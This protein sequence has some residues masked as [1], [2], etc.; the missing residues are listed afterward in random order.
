MGFVCEGIAQVNINYQSAQARYAQKRQNILAQLTKESNITGEQ[1]T[2]LLQD[3]FAAQMET[4]LLSPETDREVGYQTIIGH[5][6]NAARS[7]VYEA[8]GEQ[9]DSID[10]IKSAIERIRQETIGDLEKERELVAKEIDKAVADFAKQIDLNTIFNKYLP[11]VMSSSNQSLSVAQIMGYCKSI[12]KQQI[13]NKTGVAEISKIFKRHPSII[14]GYI[15]EDAFTKAALEVIEQLQIKG[16]S[17]K[18]VGS[19]QSKI[20]ILISLGGAGSSMSGDLSGI[21][22]ML[23]NLGQNIEVTGSAEYDT[24][25]FL[26]VQAKPWNLKKETSQ[27][28]RNSIGSRTDLKNDFIKMLES[29]GGIES[30]SWHKGVLYLSEHLE[31]VMGANTVMYATGKNIIWADDLLRDMVNEYRKYFAFS[32]DSNHK[33]TSHIVLADHWC[34]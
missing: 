17:A 29:A 7:M 21:L 24:S 23:D 26:G 2:T 12:F 1:F 33:L 34:K 30:Y 27:W 3:K 25:Q 15:R 8:L 18:T 4:K 19:E 14:M 16:A 11:Q 9:G 20:D 32:L 10:S 31:A 6:Y 13:Q 28:N 22:S 5:I